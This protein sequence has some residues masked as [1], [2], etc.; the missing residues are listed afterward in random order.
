MIF[1]AE[2]DN[3]MLTTEEV[4]AILRRSE[5]TVAKMFREGKFPSVVKPGGSWLIKRSDL[6]KDLEEMKRKN[7][8]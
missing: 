8:K 5:Y 4:A 6:Y 7:K 3:D 2:T 1:M